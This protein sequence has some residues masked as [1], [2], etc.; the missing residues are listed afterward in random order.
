MDASKSAGE[1]PLTL[2][3]A[4][5]RRTDASRG[6][7]D[8]AGRTTLLELARGAEG[9][10][11]PGRER[12]DDPR[13]RL[14]L[15]DQL[16]G[17]GQHLGLFA[18]DDRVGPRPDRLLR[19]VGD[20]RVELAGANAPA[21]TGPES[22]ALELGAQA[23]GARAEPVPSS[24]AASGARSKPSSFTSPT[25]CFGISSPPSGESK[26][27]RSPPAPS[28]AFLSAAGRL[29]AGDR[30]DRGL[31]RKVGE[32]LHDLLGVLLSP[33][34]QRRRRAGS[35]GSRFGRSPP[36]RTAEPRRPPH[37]VPPRHR[38]ARAR[39]G[40]P[41]ALRPLAQAHHITVNL[42]L[43][44]AGDQVRGLDLGH[45]P[46]CAWQ[47]RPGLCRRHPFLHLEA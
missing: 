8:L 43:V 27:R 33:K 23:H 21:L 12:I 46:E 45:R 41:F 34:R 13:H 38:T 28:T 32:G 4:S 42:R 44:G 26:S 20:H 2:E 47:F 9:L 10:P 22:E 29:S 25:R 18:L 6:P 39:P 30:R 24:R 15:G 40:P 16:L 14:P 11:Q 36:A 3:T 35:G 17:G 5:W 1:R 19:G 31:G 37:P 7:R